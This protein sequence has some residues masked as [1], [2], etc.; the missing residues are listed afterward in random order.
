LRSATKL[1]SNINDWTV[2]DLGGTRREIAGSFAN[3]SAALMGAVSGGSSSNY[4]G[5]AKSGTAGSSG[6]ISSAL[7]R[8]VQE[9]NEKDT[10]TDEDGK[11]LPVEADA[12]P[13][14]DSDNN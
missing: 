7:T 1:K 14:S 12:D 11:E 3:N 2:T 13:E 10:E 9:K 8:Q 6:G 5:T 4:G